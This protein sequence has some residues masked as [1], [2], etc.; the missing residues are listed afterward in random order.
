MLLSKELLMPIYKILN[1]THVSHTQC[2]PFTK[3]CILSFNNLTDSEWVAYHKKIEKERAISMAIGNFHQCV[4]GS[5]DGWVNYKTGHVSGCDI[6]TVDDT[7]VVE[8][9]NNTNTMNSDSKKNVFKKL[10]EQKQA[11]KR[12]ILV[13]I[14]SN[15]KKKIDSN[16][17]EE[18][19]GREFY[20][21]LSGSETFFDD[22][23][24][25]FTT[26]FTTYK[27]FESVPENALLV[28][29]KPKPS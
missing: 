7:C 27:T 29:P 23:M 16:G 6:G 20:T 8:I 22:L 28:E 12:A 3:N 13:V 1:D 18:I 11:G 10:L 15:Q 5:F 25:T 19:S 4:M 14:N 24:R 26:V 2:D 9:K 17:I 21:D